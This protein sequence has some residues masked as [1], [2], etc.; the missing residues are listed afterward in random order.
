MRQ[1]I[2]TAGHVDHGKSTL[3]RALTGI[4]PDRWAEEKRRGLTI[5]LGFAWATLPSG[6]EVSFVDVP[7]H[8]RFLGNM[9]AG[10]GPVPIVCF[11]VAADEGWQ[12]QSADHRDAIA[13]LGIDQ[14]LLVVTR[15][16]LASDNVDPVLAQARAE[17]AGTGLAEAPAIAVSAVTGQ[18]MGEL[19]TRLD[20]V[21]AGARQPEATDRVRL[22]IDRSFTI[23]GAGTIVTGTLAAGRI[24]PED[25]LQL[26]G[27]ERDGEVVVRGVQSRG[28]SAEVLE[29]V[30]RAAVNL[31]GVDAGH[32]GRGD[33]LLTPGAWELTTRVDVR[34]MT[35][36]TFDDSPQELIVHVG[37]AAVTAQVRPLGSGHARLLLERPLPLAVGDRMVLRGSG[38]RA[39]HAGVHALDVDPPDLTRRG[40][41]ARRTETLEDLPLGGDVAG[42]VARRGAVRTAQLGRL[43]L[44]V[45]GDLGTAVRREGDWLVHNQSFAQWVERLDAAVAADRRTDPL[46]A[47]LPRRAALNAAAVPDP[48]LLDAVVAVAGLSQE[49]GRIRARDAGG[50]GPA[51]KAVAM[52]E[53]RLATAPFQAPEAYDLADLHL[54]PKELAAAA[55]HGRLLRLPGEVILAP[56]APALAMRELAGLAQPFTLSQARQAL[57]TTRRVAV[58]LLEH[59]D[60]RGWTRRLDSGHR[61]IVR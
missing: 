31:R 19:R 57:G 37:T 28:G 7:G 20:E 61:E 33:A 30:T 55:R 41:G 43:G 21:V 42:E 52:L 1:V 9:L 22:W 44:D 48:E 5:D 34:R 2:A 53:Q 8:E 16:D 51:E 17:L 38:S 3:I 15:A 6:R 26:S 4:E 29:P 54:G 56:A 23:S 47:G 32:I 58:P 39:V 36:A 14:G 25:R 49:Q 45:T 18:G 60:S 13:A 46:S 27:A 24:R 10:L 12:A 11:V 35:G 50:L 59:L 40:D